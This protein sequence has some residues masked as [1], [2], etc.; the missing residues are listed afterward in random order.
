MTEPTIEP[1][2][3]RRRRVTLTDKMIEGLAR[4]RDR[5]IEP[6]PDQR[7]L[8]VRVPARD[9][10]SAKV[11]VVISRYNGKPIWHTLGDVSIGIDKARK[12]AP[13]VIERIRQGLPPVEAPPPAPPP[14]DSVADVCAN[15]VKRYVKPRKLRT[16]EDI[17]RLIGVYI[18]PHIG[19]R[20]FTSIRRSDVAKLG[21]L[22][23]DKHGGRTADRVLGV[24][25]QVCTWYAERAPDDYAVPFLP[26]GTKRDTG[27]ARDRVLT[28]DEI[29]AIWSACDAE[30]EFG[31]F[32]KFALLCA[33]RKGIILDMRWDDVSPDGTWTVRDQGPRAKHDIGKVKLPKLALDIIASQPRIADKPQIFA[34]VHGK[35][36]LANFTRCQKRLD[37]RAGITVPWTPH[38]LRRSAATLM[39]RAGV[40]DNIVER[41]L[42]HAIPGVKGIYNR[43][44]Y[45]PQKT[46]ALDRLANL[47]AEIVG[48][49]HDDNVVPLRA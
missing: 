35:G 37:A 16:A 20:P 30:P 29:R 23:E 45:Q 33:Q 49:S 44:E 1:R 22:I 42:G 14:P 36:A 24:L 27:G 8:Y 2:Q 15:W 7:G 48:L 18:L 12:L 21:D 19:N 47:I 39:P 43:Y 31:N 11:F 34:S 32:I 41:V 9:S 5:Y 10:N 17:E 26:R 6:D 28:D 38:D 40:E 4:G 13:P 25:R 46:A 3:R